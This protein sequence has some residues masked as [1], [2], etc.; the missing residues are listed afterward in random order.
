MSNQCIGIAACAVVVAVSFS[1]AAHAAS[2]S[3]DNWFVSLGGISSHARET[4]APGNKWN[5]THSGL[6][7]ESRMQGIPWYQAADRNWQ[8]RY[9]FGTL[10]DSRNYWGGYA[11]MGLMREVAYH[12]PLR[13]HAGVNATLYYRSTSWSGTMRVVPAILP[14]LSLTEYR[15]GIGLNMVWVPP[16]GRDTV[17]T[18]LVQLTYRVER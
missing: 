3:D 1:G 9:A 13:L 2:P 4:L 10:E 7:L 11:G 8:T 17:S 12:G 6:G 5:D 14:A 18:L 16:L 15:S